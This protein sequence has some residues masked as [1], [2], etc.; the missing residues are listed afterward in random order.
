MAGWRHAVILENTGLH[1]QIT[2]KHSGIRQESISNLG[3]TQIINTWQEVNRS[4]TCMQ[5]SGAPRVLQFSPSFPSKWSQ[6]FLVRGSDYHQHLSSA[7]APSSCRNT[8]PCNH[9]P[10]PA[11][12]RSVRLGRRLHPTS[13]DHV[14]LSSGWWIGLQGSHFEDRAVGPSCR[15]V[16]CV[17]VTKWSR[18]SNVLGIFLHLFI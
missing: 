8:Q 15:T 17:S 14:C 7:S 10:E 3:I 6:I 4:Q 12:T 11:A 9:W 5:T 1:V 16:V 2:E 18:G 13:V